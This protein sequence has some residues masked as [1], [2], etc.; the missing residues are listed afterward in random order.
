VGL[1]AGAIFVKVV[2]DGIELLV[3][4]MG[5]GVFI[6]QSKRY[7]SVSK[8]LIFPPGCWLASK[9]STENPCLAKRM[10]VAMPAIPAPTTMALF[11]IS[12]NNN[13]KV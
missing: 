11:D 4:E 8:A 7:P 1:K 6:A 3:V 5:F 10:D 13:P 2:A 12:Y 9:T